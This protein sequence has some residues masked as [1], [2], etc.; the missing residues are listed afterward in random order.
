MASAHV[1]CR[2]DQS[3]EH[4]SDHGGGARE[5]CDAIA[6]Y[7]NSKGTI[8]FPLTRL[9]PVTLIKRMVKTRVAEIR[10]K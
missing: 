9:P 7:K 2:V 3:H 5:A 10:G 8:Q 1:V 4:V 6:G